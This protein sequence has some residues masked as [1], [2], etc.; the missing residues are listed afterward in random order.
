MKFQS[1]NLSDVFGVMAHAQRQ[2]NVFQHYNVSEYLIAYGLCVDT[3]YR[4]RGI[5]T[6]MLKARGPLMSA[7]GLQVTTTAFTGIG[8]QKAAAKAGYVENFVIK[9]GERKF[10]VFFASFDLLAFIFRYDELYQMNPDFYFPGIT[11][12]HFKTMSLTI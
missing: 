5:A 7:L 12:T 2:F 1:Q 10:Y 3:M 6:E 4:Q 11:T 8:S 9:W